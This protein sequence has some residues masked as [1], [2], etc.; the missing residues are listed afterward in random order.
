MRKLDQGRSLLVQSQHHNNSRKYVQGR[1]YD[2]EH[3]NGIQ[4]S[5]G[6]YLNYDY[7]SVARSEFVAS[8]HVQSFICMF[9]V[10]RDAGPYL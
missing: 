10:Q 1:L 8:L 6:I 7:L 9:Q 2:H 4:S 3:L 5:R